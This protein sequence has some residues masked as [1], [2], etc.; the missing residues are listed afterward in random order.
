MEDHSGWLATTNRLQTFVDSCLRRILGVWWPE[1]TDNERLWQRAWQRRWRWTGHTNCKP[2]TISITWQQEPREEM[3][4]GQPR[5][6]WH[7]DL[8]A[9]A[10]KLD[11]TWE[12]GS[13]PEC[14]AEF[15]FVAHAPGGA[16][17]ALIDWLTLP[18]FNRMWMLG[19]FGAG[20]MCQ[21]CQ[22]LC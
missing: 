22:E 8:E 9:D 5:N 4:R 11:I 21:I 13:G 14:L 18:W 17:R 2:G 16:T 3:E 1:T 15:I 19:N 6:T 7:C 20:Q 12:T 10:N